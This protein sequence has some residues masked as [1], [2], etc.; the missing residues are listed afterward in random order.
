MAGMAWHGMGMAWHGMA[1]EFF[2]QFYT[3]SAV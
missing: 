2:V 1:S 3:F